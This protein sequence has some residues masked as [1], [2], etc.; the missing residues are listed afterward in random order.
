LGL[1]GGVLVSAAAFV[2]ALIVALIVV[3]IVKILGIGDTKKVDLDK[4]NGDD[5]K[6]SLE[7]I[8]NSIAYLTL[9]KLDG[10]ELIREGVPE[11]EKGDF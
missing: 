3:A 1:T 6:V 4:V 10:A 8:R 9:E 2:W 7:E 11:A 5:L